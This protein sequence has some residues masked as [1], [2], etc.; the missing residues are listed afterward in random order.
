MPVGRTTVTAWLSTRPCGIVRVIVLL[1]TFATLTTTGK[2]V[3]VGAP[4]GIV[5]LILFSPTFSSETG[6]N[7]GS[8]VFPPNCKVVNDDNPSKIPSG[9][10]R[11]WL[12]LRS[13]VV[14]KSIPV[15]SSL[16]NTVIPLLFKSRFVIAASWMSFTLRQSVTPGTADAIASTIWGVR[17]QTVDLDST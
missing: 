16:F 9:K 17:S 3:S 8:T 5:T 10:L 7:N 14:S 1:R 15:K 4:V 11:S 2:T 6:I 13:S 12:L